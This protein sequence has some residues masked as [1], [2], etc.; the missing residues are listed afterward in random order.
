MKFYLRRNNM[1]NQY[2]FIVGSASNV[3]T[4]LNSKFSEGYK[5]VDLKILKDSVLIILEREEN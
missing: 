3:K 5:Y 1:K 2:A 4:F